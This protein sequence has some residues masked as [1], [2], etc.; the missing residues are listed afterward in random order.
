MGIISLILI[1]STLK[2][3]KVVNASPFSDWI[4]T[5]ALVGFLTLLMMGFFLGG[6]T[7]A[8]TSWEELS[9]F[10]GGVLLLFAFVFAERRAK[11]PVL[12]P[13][14]FRIRNVSA[15]TAVNI[16]RAMVLFG[17]IAYVP[18]FAQAVLRGNISDVRNVVYALALPVTAG[19]LLSGAAI[20]RVGFKKPAYIGAAITAIGLLLL[21]ETIESSSSVVQLMEVAVPIGLGNGVMIPATIVAFQNSVEKREIGIAS[22]LA[23]FTLNLGGAIGVAILGAIQVSIFGSQLS[24]LRA[25]APA[26]SKAILG[27]PNLVGQILASPQALARL[28]ASNG[29]FA[30]LVPKLRDVFSQSILPLFWG[31]LGVSVVTFI[32]VLFMKEMRRDAKPT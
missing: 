14:L 15:A 6:S 13:R 23:T 30:P 26:G 32:M 20:S 29:S 7:F 10:A 2:E 1:F 21:T 18:L 9:L 27:D 25:S 8:W 22:G 5:S 16:L 19:I 17:L 28:I 24:S 3:S 12:P 31:V 4:G 11:E